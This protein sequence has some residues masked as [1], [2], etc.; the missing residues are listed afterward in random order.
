LDSKKSLS[1]ACTR[2]KCVKAH[3]FY[4]LFL[5]NTQ[6]KKMKNARFL[7]WLA[8]A[9][10]IAAAYTLRPFVDAESVN[11]GLILW[12]A[13]GLIL[14]LAFRLWRGSLPPVMS[15]ADIEAS[16]PEQPPISRPFVVLGVG[17]LLVLAEINGRLLNIPFLMNVSYHVQ[18]GLLVLGC[19]ALVVGFAGYLGM[20]RHA[21]TID[22]SLVAITLLALFV[23]SWMLDSAVHIW[24][25]E[26]HFADVVIKLWNNPNALLLP[27]NPG[28]AAFTSVYAYLQSITISIFGPDLTGLRV[29]SVI[30]GTFTIPAV[31]LL[32]HELFDRKTALLAALFLA[33]FPPQI[34][35]SRLGLNN[36]AD[37]LFGVLALAFFMRGLKRGRQVD[38]AISGV[39]LGLT[40][41]FYEGGKLLYPALFVIWARLVIVF[42]RPQQRGLLIFAFT[43]LMVAL[44][45][46]YLL[47]GKNTPIMPRLNQMTIAPVYL[48][49]ERVGNILEYWEKSIKPP[50]LHFVHRPDDSRF[51]YGGETP[52]ILSYL[53]P[54]FMLGIFVALWRLRM[55][56]ALLI[57]WVIGTILGNSLIVQSTWTARF[58][59]VFPAVALLIAAGIR[60]T[61]PLLWPFSTPRR[62]LLALAALILMLPQVIY[63]FAAHIPIYNEQ[64][65]PFTDHIDVMYRARSLAPDTSIYLIYNKSVVYVP[66]YETLK[67]FWKFYRRFYVRPADKLTFLLLQDLPRDV[68]YAFFVEPGDAATISW[69]HQNFALS[70][71]RYSPYNVPWD[72]QYVLLYAAAAYNA[73]DS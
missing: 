52:M 73:P 15:K 51:F 17:A 20:T 32:A 54:F 49:S 8:L 21:P 29:P 31:Y 3:A 62:G 65:R 5:Q 10:M 72:K 64:V 41:Y 13:G 35:L 28:I 23:N 50:L 6:Q 9:L 42:W 22:W 37:P 11:L 18:F 60:F 55:V 7:V 45:I 40:Q 56:G 68:N 33:V 24:I 47:I 27:S 53:V 44:P 63:Y 39:M 26:F 19:A 4:L 48:S 57:I 38:Y 43:A 16:S 14:G 66:H 67:P 59:V 25:D 58:V 70:Q 46:Y 2:W 34:H 69:L 30:F 71:P 61:L 36:I 1:L 12:L